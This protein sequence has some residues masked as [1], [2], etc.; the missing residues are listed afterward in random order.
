MKLKNSS[1]PA[2]H[3]DD[4][5][6][7]KGAAIRQAWEETGV[8][9]VPEDLHGEGMIYRKAEDERIDFV[10]TATRWDEEPRSC[11]VDERDHLN[12][13]DIERV[14]ENV[15]PFARRARENHQAGY[16]LTASGGPMATHRA[17]LANL[18]N[19]SG[20]RQTGP[21]MTSKSGAAT[22]VEHPCNNRGNVARNT[23]LFCTVDA[24]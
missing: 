19:Q 13:G 23:T 12:G 5:E 15:I 7:V 4:G 1:V 16:R 9:I 2:D 20:L 8:E 22:C 3:L 14:P 18:I 10:V 17:T 21:Y 24:A 11:E 6:Q